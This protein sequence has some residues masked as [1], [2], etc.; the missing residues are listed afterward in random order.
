M[1]PYDV[2]EDND[3]GLDDQ[4]V[5]LHN[6]MWDVYM[7]YKEALIK[8]GCSVEVSG[9]DGY[10]VL[11]E[12]VDDHVVE[13]GNNHDDIGLRGGLFRFFWHIQGEGC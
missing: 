1:S 9:S 10:K 12:V 3:G 4:K 2:F 13:E 5:I 11:W 7:N 6:K 8:G